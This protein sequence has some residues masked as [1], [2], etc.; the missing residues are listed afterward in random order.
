MFTL[1]QSWRK[2]ILCCPNLLADDLCRC[3][4]HLSSHVRL[5]HIW[6][7]EPTFI[8][9]CYNTHHSFSDSIPLHL[10]IKARSHF[11]GLWRL[12]S[13][14]SYHL[15]WLHVW[16]VNIMAFIFEFLLVANHALRHPH[17]ILADAW[18]THGPYNQNSVTT[19]CFNLLLAAKGKNSSLCFDDRGPK[20][21]NSYGLAF[22]WLLLMGGFLRG[23]SSKLELYESIPRPAHKLSAFEYNLRDA[24]NST[25]VTF[26][27][28]LDPLADE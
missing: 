8:L 6:S 20:V 16:F 4:A 18:F 25:A 15:D 9:L 19:H 1:V 17:L 27:E 14:R 13:F 2:S 23:T 22:A 28:L 26:A 24:A 12:D 5:M 11:Y 3:V 7:T 10:A 21:N